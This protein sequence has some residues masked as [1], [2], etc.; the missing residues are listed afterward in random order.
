MHAPRTARKSGIAQSVHCVVRRHRHN[1]RGGG[2]SRGAHG[3]P[4]DFD[5]TLV[6]RGGQLALDTREL[7]LTKFLVS[8]S[9]Q[10]LISSLAS[11]LVSRPAWPAVSWSTRSM[12]RVGPARPRCRLTMM[13]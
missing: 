11:P 2:K 7:N 10:R 6:P 8:L 13:P 4:S 5:W 12:P 1:R 3:R 9:T